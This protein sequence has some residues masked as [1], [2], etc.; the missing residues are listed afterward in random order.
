MVNVARAREGVKRDLKTCTVKVSGGAGTLDLVATSV[1]YRRTDR[2]QGGSKIAKQ[3]L[4]SA[5]VDT[6]LL[7]SSI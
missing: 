5:V 1:T 6:S 7:I 4:E 3:T 2:R